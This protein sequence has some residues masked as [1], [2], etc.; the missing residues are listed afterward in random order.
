M[1]KYIKCHYPQLLIIVLTMNN[2]P[3]I[4]STVLDLD[5]AGIVLKQGVPLD[6]PKALAAL[7]NGKKFTLESVTKL[8][9]KISSNGYGNKRISSKESARSTSLARRGFSG[10]R[11][12][13][14]IKTQHQDYQ[15]PEEIS[16]DETGHR[17]RHRL[18][19]LPVF[20]RHAAAG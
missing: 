12:R 20:H 6:L 2:N 10:H 3:A 7:R 16:D 8:L 18:I 11:D 1:I 13:Q 17:E 19:Q 15:Q 5:I 9:E 14:E 4:L